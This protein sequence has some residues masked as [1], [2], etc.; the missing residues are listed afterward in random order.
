MKPTRMLLGSVVVLAFVIGAR[1]HTVPPQATPAQI[2]VLRAARLIDARRCDAH[3]RD[4]TR[5]RRAHC[6]GRRSVEVPPGAS[7]LTLA[8]P[9]CSRP[10]RSAHASDEHV[11]ACIGK[12]ASSRQLQRMTR[13]GVRQRAPNAARRLYDVS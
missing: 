12:M 2:K 7:S 3:P 4:G 5:G 8:T 10:D 9:H 6:C 1:A 13:S 11:W